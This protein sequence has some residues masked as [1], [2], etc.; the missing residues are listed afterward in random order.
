MSDAGDSMV[1][2]VSDSVRRLFE[3]T[4]LLERFGHLRN[5]RRPSAPSS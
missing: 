3:I 5:M 1:I 2:V 4:G